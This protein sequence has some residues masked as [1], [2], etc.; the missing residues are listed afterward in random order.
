MLAEARDHAGDGD[1]HET[2][3]WRVAAADP[4]NRAR[5]IRG[6][7]GLGVLAGVLVALIAL[8]TACL[9]GV[10]ARD[11]ANWFQSEPD[12][13]D[14]AGVPQRSRILAADGT[15]IATFF[16]ENRVDVRLDQVAPVARRAVLAIED[17]RFYEHGAIDSQGTLRALISNLDSGEVTQGGSGITQQYVKNL[18]LTTAQSEEEQLAAKEVSAA[19]KVRE[20]RYAAAMERRFSKDEI[21]ARY[22]N[23]AYFGGG[24]YGIEAA[25]RH[26]FSK[27]AARLTLTEAALLA[28]VIRYP[29]AYD[30]VRRPGAAKERRDVVI[31]RMAELGWITRAEAGAAVRSPLGLRIHT[32]RSGCVT[33]SAPFFCDYVQREILTNPVFGAT[34]KEREKLLKRGGL[35]I[36]TTLDRRTQKA[37][38]R[39]VD[40]HVPHKNSARKAAAEALVE[41]GTGEIKGMVVDRRLGPDK[42]RGKTWINF[43]AD[44]SHGSSIGMQAGSTFKA[45]TLAAALE[46]DMPFGTRLMAPRAFTPAGF[47]DCAGRPVNSSGALRNSADGEGGKTFSLVTG[48]HHSVNTFFLA[49]ER[50]VGL[51]DTVKMAERLGMRQANGKRMGQYPSF[52][53]GAAQV[54]PLRLAAAYAAF[55]ARGRYCEPIAIKQITD[56]AGKRLKVPGARCRQVMDRGVADAVNHVLR[57]VLTKGTARGMGLGR[58]AA[59]KTGTVDDFSAAWFAGYTPDLAAAV[60][61]GDPRGG[62]RYPMTS[63]C[64]DGRCYG[65]VFGA[66]IPAPIWRDSMTGALAGRSASAFHRPPSRYFSKGTGEDRVTLPDVRGMKV[67]EAVDR[68]R[69]AGFRARVA[70]SVESGE[71]PKGTVAEMSP[72]P[73][74]VEPGGTV[75]LRP[76]KGGGDD[77]EPDDPAA[78]PVTPRPVPPVTPGPRPGE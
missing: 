27:S 73:G 11:A 30:P 32:T 66:T 70:G 29:Y 61:V 52:T 35:T 6:L 9:T 51:C 33:S 8:P 10:G 56:S 31:N 64:M 2:G 38:Q 19:R 46:E 28:G 78:P 59:G 20:L 67:R 71:Y 17:S 12:D 62:Y 75:T 55:G 44:A 42:E 24:A 72:G 36:R 47:R 3:L 65:A 39:A 26:F 34:A 48:T 53:L 23:I 37:A 49:L 14:T 60:W 25:S 22:L 69:A 16:Y 45:F 58:P 57:G 1:V 18:L 41:P 13:L 63:L 76:S 40:R 50:E 5:A 43:A 4:P 68:L 54:S 77:E 74:R 7:G 21:L 15:V